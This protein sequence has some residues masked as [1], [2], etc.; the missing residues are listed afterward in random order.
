MP[1]PGYENRALTICFNSTS[2][3]P[4]P[5]NRLRLRH[6]RFEIQVCLVGHAGLGYTRHQADFEDLSDDLICASSGISIGKYHSFVLYFLMCC[7]P[8]PSALPGLRA[9][10]PPKL[11]PIPPY[12]SRSKGKQRHERPPGEHARL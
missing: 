10:T 9:S 12:S 5:V 2:K 7:D 11:H 8:R 1:P 6:S 3:S 4:L